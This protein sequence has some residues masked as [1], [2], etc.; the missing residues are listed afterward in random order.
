MI[1]LDSIIDNNW[2]VIANITENDFIW[3]QA[4][5]VVLE[6]Y[7]IIYIIGGT[8]NTFHHL[9]ILIS[10]YNPSRILIENSYSFASLNN[11]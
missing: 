1:Y 3:S 9:Y 6:E 2:T 11:L 4:R 10:Y 5:S 7:A 8:N